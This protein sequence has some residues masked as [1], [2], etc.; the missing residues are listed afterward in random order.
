MT[1]DPNTTITT[2]NTISDG[3]MVK[4]VSGALMTLR[5][6][7]PFL[8]SVQK[9][10]SGM[11]GEPGQTFNI[12]VQAPRAAQDVVPANVVP[13]DGGGTYSN[14]PLTLDKW[15]E[16]PFTITNY[17]LVAMNAG[18]LIP[19][20]IKES[21]R[22]IANDL[23]DYIYGKANA[24]VYG[25]VGSAAA[26]LFA[27]N[28]NGLADLD[29]ILSKQLCPV[30]Q[31][32]LALNIGDATAAE[33]LDDFKKYM[34]LG[35]VE[36]LRA[37]RLGR[38][39]NTEIHR[40]TLANRWTA[41]SDN[42]SYVLTGNITAQAATYPGASF[43]IGV[44]TGTGTI[45]AGDLV[46]IGGSADAQTYVVT[47]ALNTG[48]LSISPPPAIAH[49]I[50][51]TVKVIGAGTTYT[52]NLAFDPGLLA[53]V[54]RVP[55]FTSIGGEPLPTMGQHRVMVDPVTGIPLKLSSY[56]MFEQHNFRLSYLAGAVVADPRRGAFALSS[57]Y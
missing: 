40:Q 56:P 53:L 9:Q 36:A 21:A 55:N 52:R 25:A 10:Y 47:S 16:V 23:N 30:G 38:I 45:L 8:A 57:A 44:G 2:P 51:D 48:V 34:N 17:E 42:G 50:G 54:M 22:A 7:L 29:Y 6:E 39:Y 31:R 4:I 14:V 35:D 5:E 46:Q 26:G 27:A 18:P 28:I 20:A 49:S 11:E 37:G 12:Q 19:E 43:Q 41:G 33:K 32:Q 13:N 15:R 3:L 1:Y 24:K